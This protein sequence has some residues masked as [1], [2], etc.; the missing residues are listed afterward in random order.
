MRLCPLTRPALHGAIAVAAALAVGCGKDPILAAVDAMEES[1]AP[2]VNGAAPASGEPEAGVPAEPEPGVPDN[3]S[4]G[5]GGGTP[6]APGVEGLA[7]EPA[8]GVPEE[9]EPGVPTAPEPAAAGTAQQPEPPPSQAGQGVA[10]EPTPG[11]PEE[12]KPAPPGSPGGAAH[13]GKDDGQVEEEGPQAM[14]RGRV[15]APQGLGMIRIDLFD[16]DQRNVAGPRP[17]VVGVHEIDDPGSFELSVA[18][19]HKRVWLGAYRDTN[20][21]KRPDKGEPSGWYARNPV[22]LDSPPSSLV[23]TLQV[24]GKATGLGLDFGGP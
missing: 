6:G 2:R 24:E 9:P 8:K 11:V 5:D 21:N 4:P 10:A 22:F 20:G 19:S 1:D 23:I 13:K 12:P 3:P 16:G 14:V 18:L 15:D 7:E 17:K